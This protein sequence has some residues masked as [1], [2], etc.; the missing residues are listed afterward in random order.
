[1]YVV[2][3]GRWRILSTAR[4]IWPRLEAIPY[5]LEGTVP[6]FATLIYSILKSGR[7]TNTTSIP[8]HSAKVLFGITSNF[9]NGKTVYVL[10]HILSELQRMQ[11][12]FMFNCTI[13][14][15]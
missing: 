10:I 1:M 8:I 9:F 7:K 12:E 2:C 11:L 4:K 3:T 14:R 13:I 6:N 15:N 5:D